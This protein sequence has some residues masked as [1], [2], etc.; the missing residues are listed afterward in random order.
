MPQI[1]SYNLFTWCFSLYYLD[2]NYCM[3][4]FEIWREKQKIPLSLKVKWT[5]WAVLII[6]SLSWIRL[7]T[8][9][10]NKTIIFI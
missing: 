7:D 5:C 4:I 8:K 2:L 3:K 9:Q 10:T 1:G 6:N